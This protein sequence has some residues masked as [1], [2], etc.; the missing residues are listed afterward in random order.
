MPASGCR[1]S[2]AR[3][4]AAAQTGG[5]RSQRLRW[6]NVRRLFTP[7]W[8]LRHGVMVVLVA[9][10][11]ALTRWQYLRATGGNLQSW[12]YTLQWPMFAGYVLAVW[13]KTV[14]DEIRSPRDPAGTP[15]P[16]SPLGGPEAVRSGL[17]AGSGG[18]FADASRPGPAERSDQAGTVVAQ[19]DEDPDLA[20]Y[21]RYLRWL[22]AHP[23]RRPTEYPG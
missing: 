4:G 20:A 16:G 6:V 23:D 10:C 11:G 8:L 9:T 19:E 18:H 5:L 1:A 7:R 13:G 14:R 21:N 2:P 17:S 15:A 3:A 12:G 22:N